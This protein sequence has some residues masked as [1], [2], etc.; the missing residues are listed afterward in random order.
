M[1]YMVKVGDYNI[2]I[3]AELG[4]GTFGKVYRGIHATNS[5]DVG[6][7][8]IVLDGSRGAKE[9]VQTEISNLSRVKHHPLILHL[10]HHEF[11]DYVDEFGTDVHELWLITDFCEAGNLAKYYKS[12]NVDFAEKVKIG[13]QCAG[14]IAFLHNME[15]PMLHRDIKPGNVLI[16]ME[17]GTSRVKMADFG[18]AQSS[19]K[20][21]VFST[22]GGSMQYMSPELFSSSP[23][24]RKS[25]DVFSL[26]VLLGHLVKAVMKQDLEDEAC[27]YNI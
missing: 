21:T 23:K 8:K 20:K 17:E 18:L 16:K 7:K 12:N 15:P 3:R 19:D 22:V 9:F 27:E 26:G 5:I 11:L 24:Y 10:M 25:I 6:A 1:A 14:A 13:R 2:S 4:A